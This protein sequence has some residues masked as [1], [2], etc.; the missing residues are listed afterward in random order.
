MKP[1]PGNPDVSTLLSFRGWPRVHR[2]QN[3]ESMFWAAH[4]ELDS[5]FLAALGPGMTMKIF[6]QG[7]TACLVITSIS[8]CAA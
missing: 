6:T 1:G 7:S 2:G 3:P 4:E 8:P 5:G